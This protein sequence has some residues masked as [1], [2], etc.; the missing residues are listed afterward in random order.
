MSAPQ[1]AVEPSSKSPAKPATGHHLLWASGGLNNRRAL[2]A[3]DVREPPAGTGEKRGDVHIRSG[4]AYP[5]SSL[6]VGSYV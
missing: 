2:A 5:A 3:V 6:K 4:F 1:K